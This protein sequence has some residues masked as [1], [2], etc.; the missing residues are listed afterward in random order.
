MNIMDRTI[1]FCHLKQNKWS[2]TAQ[3]LLLLLEYFILQKN[4]YILIKSLLDGDG[5]SNSG[6]NSIIN[7]S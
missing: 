4:V 6:G 1:I 2:I 3:L 5:D 7:L